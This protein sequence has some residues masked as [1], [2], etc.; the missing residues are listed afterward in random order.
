M[1]LVSMQMS[2]EEAKE[3]AGIEPS[4]PRYP[5]GLCIDLNDETLA[6][7]GITE[8]PAVGA[9]ITVLARATVTRVSAYQDQGNEQE[10]CVGLQITDME[11]EQA[12][13]SAAEKLYGGA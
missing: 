7:L 12:G 5:Y 8:L 10:R 2:A 9:Q 4:R 6:K 1:A 3:E 11:L 13:P